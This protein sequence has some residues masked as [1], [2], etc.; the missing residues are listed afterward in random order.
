MKKI[1]NLLVLVFISHVVFAQTQFDSPQIRQRLA[2]YHIKEIDYYSYDIKK[3]DSTLITKDTFDKRGFNLSTQQRSVAELY[4]YDGKGN[5]IKSIFKAQHPTSI[6][7]TY[8]ARGNMTSSK[9]VDENGKMFGS[10]NS[11]FFITRYEYNADNE[12]VQVYLTNLTAQKRLQIKKEYITSGLERGVVRLINT[13]Y[14]DGEKFQVMQVFY[15][16]HE[17]EEYT[18][19]KNKKKLD[20]QTFLSNDRKV[21]KVIDYNHSRIFEHRSVIDA[22]LHDRSLTDTVV[23]FYKYNK[24]GYNC[25]ISTYKQNQL[26]GMQKWFYKQ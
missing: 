7:Y 26:I 2:K 17:V 13:Y 22:A 9:R 8:D 4:Q 25:E 14:L 20:T 16:N 24:Y 1:L 6:I 15:K 23:S 5:M 10:P 3:S 21:I 11:N 19:A 12:L 18:I